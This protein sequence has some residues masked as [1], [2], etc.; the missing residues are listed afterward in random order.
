MEYVS[1]EQL[2]QRQ[3][4]LKQKI[5]RRGF[6]VNWGLSMEAILIMQTW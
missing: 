6:E 4:I 2:E 1:A 3:I 5:I